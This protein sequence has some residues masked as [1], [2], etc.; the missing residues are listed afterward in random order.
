MNDWLMKSVI[1]THAIGLH[2]RPSV[3][4]TK[5]AKG[6][7]SAIE[8][9][10]SLAGPWVDAKSIVR[11]MAIKAGKGSTLHLRAKGS[12]AKAAINTLSGFVASEFD[13]D[14]TDVA[15]G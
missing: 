14:R 7:S 3:K 1:V 15:S 11:V 13:E 12:D 9:G 6:F 5:L 10:R 2:A 4:F 8:V